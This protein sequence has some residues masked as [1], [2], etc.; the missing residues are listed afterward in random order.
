MKDA[1][2]SFTSFAPWASWAP[3][4]QMPCMITGVFPAVLLTSATVT[5]IEGSAHALTSDTHALVPCPNGPQPRTRERDL[6]LDVAGGGVYFAEDRFLLS[7]NFVVPRCITESLE[8]I[9]E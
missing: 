2:I 1:S 4:V 8:I 7:R 5:L 9:V 3:R 6:V